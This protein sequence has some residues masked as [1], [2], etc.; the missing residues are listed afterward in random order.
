MKVCMS[1][2]VDAEEEAEEFERPRTHRPSAMLASV[3]GASAED[4]GSSSAVV[5]EA[6][7]KLADRFIS[8]S[9]CSAVL[10]LLLLT[11]V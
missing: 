2:A 8:L 9:A 11:A 4:G 7:G 5:C 10:M 3:R 6:D 1:T